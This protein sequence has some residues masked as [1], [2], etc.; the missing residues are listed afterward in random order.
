[1]GGTPGVQ[2]PA[3]PVPGKGVVPPQANGNKVRDDFLLMLLPCLLLEV[4]CETARVL[5][6]RTLGAVARRT[7][8][9]T[10]GARAT[11]RL[12]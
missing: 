7:Q 9:S 8:Y 3:A 2:E 5:V 10:D 1:M 4:C 11:F 6:P 12:A